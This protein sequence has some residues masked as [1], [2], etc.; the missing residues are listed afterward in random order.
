MP[1]HTPM[2]LLSVFGHAPPF[3]SA[4]MLLLFALSVAAIAITVGKLRP[5]SPLAGGSPYL[6]NLRWGGPMAGLLGGAHGAL[7]MLVGI[8]NR[9]ET[10]MP[11]LAP[12]LAEVVLL[13]A[14]GLITGIAATVANTAV[15]A[16]IDRAVLRA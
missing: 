7:N 4:V 6:S 1:T 14:L 15:E 16:R 5:G 9:G 11:V 10:P 13:V 12:G 2:T 3:V 8:A